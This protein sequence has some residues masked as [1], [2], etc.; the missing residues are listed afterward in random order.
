[1]NERIWVDM[2]EENAYAWRFECVDH[3]RGKKA[4]CPAI[5]VALYSVFMSITLLL[6]SR[7]RFFD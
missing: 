5:F 6:F 1:M 2:V 4:A 3:G 7:E